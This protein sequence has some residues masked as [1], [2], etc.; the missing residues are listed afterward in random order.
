MLMAHGGAG[1]VAV[2]TAVNGIAGFGECVTLGAPVAGA[3]MLGVFSGEKD[4]GSCR[5]LLKKNGKPAVLPG[6]SSCF[7]ALA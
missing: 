5:L 1:L 2:F 4:N 6:S 3:A 7:C